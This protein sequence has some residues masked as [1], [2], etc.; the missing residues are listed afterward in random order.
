MYEILRQKI[1]ARQDKY[2][3]YVDMKKLDN[4]LNIDDNVCVYSP[5]MKRMKLVPNWH[6]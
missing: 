6:E 4:I 3:T 2:A 1:N 5:Q